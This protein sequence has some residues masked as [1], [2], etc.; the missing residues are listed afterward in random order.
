MKR[1]RLR[2]V[3]PAQNEA[4]P[5][6]TRPSQ[7]GRVAQGE[8]TM[9]RKLLATTALAM[10]VATAAYAQEQPAPAPSDPLTTPSPRPR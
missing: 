8:G 3:P 5:L 4:Q 1:N 7:E 2:P 6:L 10:L 9:I